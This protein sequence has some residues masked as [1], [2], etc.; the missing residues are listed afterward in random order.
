MVATPSMLREDVQRYLQAASEESV[1]EI[2]RRL[3]SHAFALSQLAERIER[4]RRIG[5]FV[6]RANIE[7]YVGV[8]GAALDEDRRKTVQFLLNQERQKLESDGPPA[9]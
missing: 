4:S 5:E 8:L 3:A 6:T 7:H 2:K 9:R 1:P